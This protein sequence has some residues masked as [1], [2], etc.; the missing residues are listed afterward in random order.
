MQGCG[1]DGD[2]R[3]GKGR[4]RVTEPLLRLGLKGDNGNEGV[5]CEGRGG[6]APWERSYRI[7]VQSGFDIYSWLARLA[8]CPARK[9]STASSELRQKES[10]FAVPP[11]HAGTQACIHAY[12]ITVLCT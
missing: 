11:V 2:A 3:R 5:R 10:R 6:R 4:Q 7:G 1:T 8:L 12:M 9:F